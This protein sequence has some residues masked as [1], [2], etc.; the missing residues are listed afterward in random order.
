MMRDPFTQIGGPAPGAA[1]RGQPHFA[2]AH[3]LRIVGA[4]TER[5]RRTCTLPGAAVDG[6]HRRRAHASGRAGAWR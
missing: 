6:E 1:R 3:P 4:P 5:Q 2:P